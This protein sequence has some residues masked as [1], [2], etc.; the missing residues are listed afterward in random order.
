MVQTLALAVFYLGGSALLAYITT[1]YTMTREHRHGAM[2]LLELC[3]RYLINRNRAYDAQRGLKSR[4]LD[5]AVYAR[6]LTVI[7]DRIDALLDASYGRLAVQYPPIS[8]LVADLRREL[9]TIEAS[10]T[11]PELE[12][13]TMRRVVDMY[14][15]LRA[16]LPRRVRDND[17][18]RALEQ[19]LPV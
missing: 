8:A 15:K 13:Q 11:L 3:R 2:R 1:R 5:K 17:F 14:R 4:P 12:P 19:S 6:E 16:H 10:D 9:V 18:D 7:V